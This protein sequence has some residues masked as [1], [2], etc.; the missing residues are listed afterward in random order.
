MET[1]GIYSLAKLLG[2]RAISINAMIA[3][4]ATGEFSQ[5]AHQTIENLIE[6][7]LG[8]IVDKLL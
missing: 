1:A 4:R 6:K 5:H 2:H 8:V 3:N 7:T